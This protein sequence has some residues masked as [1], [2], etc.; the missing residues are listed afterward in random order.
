[1]RAA[2]TSGRAASASKAPDARAGARGIVNQRL[3]QGH[4]V[5]QLVH[6]PTFTM[7]VADEGHKA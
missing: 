3:E 4:C 7:Q 5:L 6:D 2:S 1:M